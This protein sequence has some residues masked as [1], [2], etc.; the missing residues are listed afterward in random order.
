[1]AELDNIKSAIKEI[2][3]SVPGTGNIY[4]SMIYASDQKQL[5]DLF[6]SNGVLNCLMFRQVK[7]IADMNIRDSN[8][9]LIDR[10]WKFVLVYGY[11]KENESER[12]FD[13]LCETL[14]KVFNSEPDLNG[15]V[16]EHSFMNMANKTDYTYHNVLCH[17]AEFEMTT[18]G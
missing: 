5:K 10:T 16:N 14:C 9:V 17:R 11:S 6:V 12:K 18:R 8:E 2:A 7:R 13:N 1:M 15:T 3:S 4:D